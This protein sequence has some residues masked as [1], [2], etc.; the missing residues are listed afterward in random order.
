VF[1]LAT[2]IQKVVQF[3]NTENVSA[4][5]DKFAKIRLLTTT[6]DKLFAKNKNCS[7]AMFFHG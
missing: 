2:L 6:K 3:R 7:N 5:S 1:G 4:F